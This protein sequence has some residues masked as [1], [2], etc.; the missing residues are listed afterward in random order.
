M[1]NN[2]PTIFI[3]IEMAHR[4]LDGKLLL[5]AEL[6]DRGYTVKIGS[7]ANILN[8][9]SISIGGIFLSIWSAHKKFASVFSR[10]KKSNIK[11]LAM[12]EESIVTIGETIYADTRLSVKTLRN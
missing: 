4:E 8:Y 9:L 12:D 3:P 1:I 10:L 11:I 2:R 7:K 5:A 6:C